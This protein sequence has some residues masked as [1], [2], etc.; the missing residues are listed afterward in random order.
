MART[1]PALRPT[2]EDDR[3]SM[4]LE[5]EDA[6]AL[7][8]MEVWS[9]RSNTPESGASI[10]TP[11]THSTVDAKQSRPGS[12][13][14]Q[15]QVS[16]TPALDS[17]DVAASQQLGLEPEQRAPAFGAGDVRQAADWDCRASEL[18]RMERALDEREAATAL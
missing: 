8:E 14:G 15:H 2:I 9:S 6:G 4:K 12:P 18:D 17:H 13:L 5:I 11:G 7:G 1:D 16:Q 3:P 10:M